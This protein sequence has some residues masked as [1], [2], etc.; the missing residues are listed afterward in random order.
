MDYRVRKL[1]FGQ[2]WVEAFNLYMDNFLPLL[3]ISFVAN[4]PFLALK[5][6]RSVPESEVLQA[7]NLFTVV[8]WTMITMT[9]YSVASAFILIFIYKK[10][11]NQPQSANQYIE[12]VVSLIIPI[13]GLSVATA[14]IV[15]IGFLA[16]FIPGLYFALGLSLAGG[17]L[18]IEGKNVSECIARSFWLT[19]GRKGEIFFYSILFGILSFVVQWVFGQL[20]ASV[21]FGIL[22]LPA[23]QVTA[24]FTQVLLAPLS[25]AIFVLIYFNIR[26]DKEGFS[27]D[28]S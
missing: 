8:L 1:S 9:I 6:P 27:L 21:D 13:V 15:G 5:Y 12:S 24:F 18:I 2:T 19:R 22:A 25:T 17:I 4:L 20:F 16:M 3:L 10:Y 26:I 14:V 11:L 28:K 7:A 23:E